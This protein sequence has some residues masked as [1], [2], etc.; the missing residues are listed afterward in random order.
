M[1]NNNVIELNNLTK[2]YGR[3]RGIHDI[4]LQVKSGEIFGF[5]GPNG[6]GKS[7]AIRTML[8]LIFATSGDVRIFDLP[9]KENREQI[10]EYV[11]YAAAEIEY[12]ETMR[13]KAFLEY[14]ASFYK[15]DCKSEMYRLATLLEL[16]LNKKIGDM[17]LGNKKKVG[18]IQAM[19]HQP[20]LLIFDEPT[21]GLDPLVQQKFFNEL[22]AFRKRG[23][24]VLFSSHILSEVGR[25]CD[26]V[27]IIRSGKLIQVSTL[28]ELQ[29]SQYVHVS[30]ITKGKD[31]ALPVT[32]EVNQV[33]RN[34]NHLSFIYKGD[35]NELVH[36]VS[37]LDL[38]DI[39]IQEPDLETIFLHFY[40]DTESKVGE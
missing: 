30:L 18:L 5:I 34:E 3:N 7:T 35:V 37:Q 40:N 17:S 26:R 39:K 10:L 28:S 24:T 9:F 12:Y 19:Q 2:Y 25:L 22:R 29:Q 14:A 6:A 27:A 13:A 32:F 1:N 23:A 36:F 21:S 4:S 15:V 38:V 11:G 20:D 8:G 33:E 31:V 16:D